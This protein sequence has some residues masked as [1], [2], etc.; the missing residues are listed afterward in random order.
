MV[1]AAGGLESKANV[2]AI[3]GVPMDLVHQYGIGG[4]GGKAGELFQVDSMV[5]K[6]AREKA[7]SNLSHTGRCILQP[8]VLT[9][10]DTPIE[11]AYQTGRQLAEPISRRAASR[12]AGPAGAT[13]AAAY[14]SPATRIQSASAGWRDRTRACGRDPAHATSHARPS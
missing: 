11:P 14:S 1:K 10:L 12:R 6:P 9:I 8:E 3:E 13:S 4:V 5:E 2:L 7:P